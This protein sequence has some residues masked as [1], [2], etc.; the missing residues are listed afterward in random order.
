VFSGEK[1]RSRPYLADGFDVR[2]LIEREGAFGR[3]LWG[4]FSLEL[5]QQV[6]HD[7]APEW[8]APAG[9]AADPPRVDAGTSAW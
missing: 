2:T 8:R 7:R 5:W 3:N 1:A 6:F 4:L 9:E